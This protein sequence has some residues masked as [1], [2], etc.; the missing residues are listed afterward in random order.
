MTDDKRKP[1]TLAGHLGRHPRRFLGAVNTPV[2]RATT[3]LFPT[4]EDLEQYDWGYAVDTTRC[5]G[6]GSCVRA[7]KLENGVPDSYFRTWV[8][9]YEIDR[10]EAVHVDSPDGFISSFKEDLVQGEPV[11]KAFF[12]IRSNMPIT[13]TVIDLSRPQCNDRI[14][15]RESAAKWGFSWIND[16]WLPPEVHQRSR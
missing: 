5:I 3:M 16:L 10:H 12:S 11:V 2:F 14:V 7:C 13:P 8:E 1:A 6:C 15:G 9:R 4:V